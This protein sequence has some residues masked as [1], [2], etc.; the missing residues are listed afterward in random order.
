[1][2]TN[3]KSTIIALFIVHFSLF[4]F[5]GCFRPIV[6]LQNSPNYPVAIFYDNQ[7]PDRP[8]E[9]IKE[10]ESTE[11]VPLESRQTANR[12]MLSRGND[13]QQKELL[14]ARLTI[15][16]KKLGAD[17]LVGVRYKYYTTQTHNGFLLTG[18]AVRYRKEEIVSQ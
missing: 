16:A 11:E 1:M 18:L 12:R 17:A 5:I 15:E 3:R 14:L 8:F 9:P 2:K 4:I 6:Y 7:R 13:M 10:L